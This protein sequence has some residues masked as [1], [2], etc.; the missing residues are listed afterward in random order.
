[1]VA[2]LGGAGCEEAWSPAR[3][4]TGKTGWV[5]L[6]RPGERRLAA[7]G[8]VLYALISILSSREKA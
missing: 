6:R 4:C 3:H 2:M 8:S 1:M 5:G 7:R